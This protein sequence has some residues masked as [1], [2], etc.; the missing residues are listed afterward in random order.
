MT[1]R[2]T[3][4]GAGPA[5][6][7]AAIQLQRYGI[8]PLVLEAEKIGGLLHNANLVENYPGFPGGISGVGLIE[9][10]KRQTEMVGVQV[11]FDIVNQ[12][13]YDGKKFLVE[14][15]H[16]Y[17]HS[18][19]VVVSSGTQPRQFTDLKIPEGAGDKIYY[20]VYPLLKVKRKRIA[21]VGAGDAAFDYAL[22]LAKRDNEVIILNRGEIIKCLPLL[23]ERS[24]LQNRIEY[25]H[26]T[27]VQLIEM[28]PKD[29]LVLECE[30]PAGISHFEVDF[31]IG[32]IGRVP[33]MDFLSDRL[34][35]QAKELEKQHLLYFIG[36]VKNGIFRQTSIAVGDGIRAAMQIFEKEKVL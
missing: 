10:F 21:I 4:I 6:I 19:M 29:Q 24:Q 11:V 25:L 17:Y 31:L 16:R 30:S 33:K 35:E 22:N 23:W 18:R 7:S 12:L 13:E 5:G 3:I 14:T 20:E 15:E 27:A 36:D 26:H 28:N 8:A 34:K 1:K 9:L 2:V 32:A